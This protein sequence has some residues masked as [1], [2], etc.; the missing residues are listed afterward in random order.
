MENKQLYKSFNSFNSHNKLFSENDK[1]LLAVSGGIDSMAMMHLFS[2]KGNTCIVAHC[3]FQL[4]GTESDED[5]LFVEEQA[6]KLGFQF[7][8]NTFDT[9][10]YSEK[11]KL[12]IQMA[13]RE[14]RYNWFRELCKA[15]HCNLIA[16]AHNKDDV[17]ETFFINLGRGTGIKG[18]TS[19]QPFNDGII[20]PLLFASRKDIKSYIEEEQIP[21]RE[22]SS[23]K[24][25]KY[26]R[27][28]LRNKIIPSLEE[29]FPNLRDTLTGNIAKLCDLHEL[30]HYSMNSLIPGVFRRENKLAYININALLVSPAPKTILFEILS[31]FGFPP[32]IIT[33]IYDAC[34]SI[35]GKQFY[36][37]SFKL[38]K[39]R[40]QF[41]LSPLDKIQT[42]KIYIDEQIPVINYPVHLEFKSFDMPEDL[43]I[44]KDKNLAL[45]DFSKVDF[46]IILRKWNPGDYFMPLGMNGLKKLSD[47]F[48]DRKLSLIDKENVWLLTSGP[49]IIWIIGQRIDERFKITQSTSR[50]LQ[51]T[52]TPK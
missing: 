22:D 41:I 26:L 42:G 4:R 16:V 46:P 34:F 11:N 52:Y 37:T 47:F 49:D 13:A 30:Y 28:Y 20:R 21:Y 10:G 51:I 48:I 3:N 35:P 44:V 39:D 25:D 15:N 12:S 9:K 27:N 40:E 2:K 32:P 29:V 24:S 17:I 1:I 45:L 6:Q 14:L 8:S 36:S 18:L 7:F 23:N 5:M 43:Q 50:I 38:V 31:E 33:E 19:I